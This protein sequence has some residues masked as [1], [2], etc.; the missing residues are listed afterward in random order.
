MM[1]RPIYGT[2]WMQA[3]GAK[4][5]TAPQRWGRQRR[6]DSF[7]PGNEQPYATKSTESKRFQL[8]LNLIEFRFERPAL[9]YQCGN[10]P[11]CP[12]LKNIAANKWRMPGSFFR[13]FFLILEIALKFILQNG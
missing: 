12:V 4:N 8:L 13:K 5:R 1:I 11:R 10:F 7:V 3:R 9:D 6:G 2:L